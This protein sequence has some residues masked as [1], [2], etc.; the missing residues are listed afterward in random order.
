MES[1]QKALTGV[2]ESMTKFS[3]AYR[4]HAVS[5]KAGF[6][7]ELKMTRA[8][9][10]EAFARTWFG[11]RRNGRDRSLQVVQTD[12][13]RSFCG[14]CKAKDLAKCQLLV[15]VCRAHL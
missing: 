10:E 6:K 14:F 2:N 3:A 12:L 8:K 9:L 13:G 1:L 15:S 4:Q 7:T 5:E 11:I